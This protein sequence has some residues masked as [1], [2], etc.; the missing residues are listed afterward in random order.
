VNAFRAWLPITGRNR[1]ALCLALVSLVMFVVWNCLPYYEDADEPPEG[2]IAAMAWPQ[3]FSPES[4]LDVFRS[5]DVDG[6]LMITAYFGIILGGL[7]VLL[8]VP[9]WQILHASNF[10]RLPLAVL[11]LIG[12]GVMLYHLYDTEQYDPAPY[13]IA[14]IFLMSLSML[15][16]SAAFFVFK[17]ELALREARSH[18]MQRNSS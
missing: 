5:P 8:T 11:N 1:V 14:T 10:I 18:G 15:S 9:L 3:I 17:N 7:L 2:I 13:W 4:Y 12:G 16:I 6:F